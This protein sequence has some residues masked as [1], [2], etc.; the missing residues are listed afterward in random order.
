LD[1]FDTREKKKYMSYEK[2]LKLRKEMINNHI[3]GYIV[4]HNDNFFN[5]SLPEAN[6]RLEWLTSFDGSAGIALVLAEKAYIFVDGRYTIQAKQQIDSKIYEIVHLKDKNLY[7]ILNSIENKTIIGIDSKIHSILNVEH[8]NLKIQNSNISIKQ[9]KDNLIDLIWDDRPKLPYNEITIHNIEYS[10]EETKT[11]IETISK[12]IDSHTGDTLIITDC[13]SISWLLNIRGS[14]LEFTPIPLSI[15]IINKYNNI[16]FFTNSKLNANI[17]KH[18][19]NN[20][21]I[22]KLNAFEEQLKSIGKRNEKVIV[23]NETCSYWI[24]KKLK[25]FGA[26]PIIKKN[27]CLK[28]KACKNKIEVNGM[29]K[30]HLRDAKSLIETL[31]WIKSHYP[32]GNLDE[33]EVS[34]KLFKSREKNKNFIGLSFPTIAGTGP[35]GAIVHYRPSKLNNREIKYG[36]LLLM[37]SGA[38]YFEGTT[39]VTRTIAIGEP[40][41]EKKVKFTKVLKGHINLATVVFPYGTT[42]HQLDILARKFLWD[43]G[44]DYDHGTGHGV[45]SCLNVHEGPQSISKRSNNV[46]LEEG[47][48][49]SNEPGFY[50]EGEYGIRIENL[51]LVKEKYIPNSNIK[52]LN[53]ETLTLAPIDLSLIDIDLLEQKEIKWINEYHR[54]VYKQVSS[55]LSTKVAEWLKEETKEIS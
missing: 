21:K 40:D 43:D 9:V 37:D 34:R 52:F 7:D 47:M 6:R 4:P 23:D 20:I 22:F 3:D 16:Q 19:G 28:L 17:K 30:A 48:I 13:E 1:Y 14:D 53:F 24:F 55:S 18:L 10:G 49:I 11:K 8:L 54:N 45:G 50:K 46:I 12:Y 38:Q 42:G 26:K 25:E 27:L 44:L 39:D 51:I 36:D 29:R 31:Y 2:I 41:K 33:I 35:N 32:D 5:E 15:V